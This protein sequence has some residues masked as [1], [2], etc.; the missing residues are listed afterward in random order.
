MKI[1]ITGHTA[2]IGK[3]LAQ[4]YLLNGHEIVGL[5]RREGN[6]IRN[7]P[8][9]CNQ[10]DPCD[11]FINNAQAGYAQT[12]LLFEMSKRWINTKKHIIVISTMMTQDPISVLP[13]L[14]MLAYHQQKIT[15][16]EMVK[17]LRYQHLGVYI[18]IVRPGYIATQPGQMVPPAANVDNWAKTLMAIFEIALQNKLSIPDISLGPDHK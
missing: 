3:A 13:G 9:I 10:I 18:T 17:Q 6:N 7:L 1:A 15:L 2:G 14:D 4:E 11:M 5:S 16:E 12:E 8:K